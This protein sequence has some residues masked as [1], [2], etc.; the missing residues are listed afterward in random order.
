MER[1][2]VVSTLMILRKLS[3]HHPKLE[4]PVAFILRIS[5]MVLSS[6]LFKLAD[7]ILLS[8]MEFKL[9][10]AWRLLEFQCLLLRIYLII[11]QCSSRSIL[12]PPL[13]EYNLS[14]VMY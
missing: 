7:F 11:F 9:L 4:H 12:S 5:Q 2:A 14:C 6:S 10:D 13:K 1:R 8:Q 3:R